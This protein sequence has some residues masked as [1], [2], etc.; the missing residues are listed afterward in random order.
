MV[1]EQGHKIIKYSMG[2][3]VLLAPFFLMAHTIALLF[4]Y[5]ATGFSSIYQFFIEFSGLLYIV[6]G[7]YYLRKLL[8]VFYSE[9]ITALTLLLLFFATN[10]LCYATIDPVNSH[11]Y[12]LS[13]F[14]VLLFYTQQ[15]YANAKTKQAV[16]VGLTIGLI[17]L[18]R[19]LNVFFIIPFLLFNVS[20]FKNL[21]QR[22][23]FFIKNTKLSITIAVICFLIMLPQ[24]IYYK[25]VTGNFLVFSYGSKEKF[26]FA[27]PHI[28]DVLFS[29]RKGWFIYTPIMLL[30]VLIISTYT[31]SLFNGFKLSI[32]ILL[33][34]Y[35][36]FVSSWWCW[37]YGGSFGQRALVDLYP[38]LSFPL[39]TFLVKLNTLNKLKKQIVGSCLAFLLLLNCFQT[40]QYKYNIIDYD[41]MTFKEYVQVFGSINSTSIKRNYLHKPDY[42]KAVLGQAE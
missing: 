9:K 41:G 31:K 26:Y 6:I 1:T 35:I 15:F 36:Y 18:V 17:I 25:Y 39:A 27:N 14:C 11:A 13:L 32:I 29:F 20:T 7:F 4:N 30:I 22:L 2:L 21:K 37:W 38:L 24:F 42:E 12:T 40:M 8:L 16:I 23:L 19:P 5:P 34:V 3:S 10:L 33:P 28:F